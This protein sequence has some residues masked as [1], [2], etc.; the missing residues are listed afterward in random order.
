MRLQ[1][2]VLVFPQLVRITSLHYNG[3]L[4]GEYRNARPLAWSSMEMRLQI[5]GA[6]LRFFL[7]RIWDL[8]LLD[9]PLSAPEMF[10]KQD[11][12]HTA[13]LPFSQ[14]L[15][16]TAIP[17]SEVTLTSPAKF[18]RAKIAKIFAANFGQIKDFWQI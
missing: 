14:L 18:F 10:N 8:S 9:F 3:D 17:S 2:D 5:L 1:S 11:W 15:H 7:L 13:D 4:T 12:R 16:S 6:I